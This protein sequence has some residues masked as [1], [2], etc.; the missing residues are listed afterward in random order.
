MCVL[1]GACAD[2]GVLAKPPGTSRGGASGAGGGNSGTSGGSATS[3]SGSG[4][5]TDFDCGE[6]E[7]PI[8]VEKPSVMLVL[9]RSGS[10]A[11]PWDHDGNPVT[12][13]LSRWDGLLSAASTLVDSFDDRMRLGGLL[14][15]H[16]RPDN[17]CGVLAEPHVAPTEGGGDQVW[18]LLNDAASLPAGGT[19]TSLALGVAAQALA[20]RPEEEPRIMVLVTD[21]VPSCGDGFD[22]AVNATKAARSDHGVL[23]FA[24]GVDVDPAAVPS[25]QA[26]AA[27]GG[28]GEIFFNGTNQEELAAALETVAVDVI[29]CR[30]PLKFAPEAPEDLQVLLDGQALEP[31][32]DCS[33][34]VG[35]AFTEPAG[36]LDTIEICESTCDALTEA[37]ELMAV[38]AC[39]PATPGP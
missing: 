33:G 25:F 17:E 6:L 24:V 21:G 30:I 11:E 1:T 10:M 15:P 27:A 7:L 35:W 32:G 34:G 16:P 28:T 13:D 20:E 19:P 2:D 4:T 18:T 26:L 37:S 9:D 36:A 3:G 23:T 12:P 14:F 8:R 38:Y 5:D 31:Q 39:P 29:R 22:A